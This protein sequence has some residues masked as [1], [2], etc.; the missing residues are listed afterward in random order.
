[1][2]IFLRLLGILG[3]LFL[4]IVLI[5]VLLLNVPQVQ[6]LAKDIGV[7]YLNKKLGTTVQLEKL[8]I[9]FPN[10]I[11]IDSLYLEDQSGDTLM[12]SGH[13][14]VKMDM[15]GLL[16]GDVQ[17]DSVRLNNFYANVDRTLPDT[18]FNFNYIID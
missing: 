9:N 12:Y 3:S 5:L 7:K 15:W 4:V 8:A 2:K 1:I 18:T 10:A 13:L 16:S 11:V 14:F 6:N 17:V